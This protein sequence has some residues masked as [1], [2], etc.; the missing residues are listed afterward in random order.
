MVAVMLL[1]AVAHAA[2][3]DALLERAR[4]ELQRLDEKAALKT[5]EQ[6]RAQAKTSPDDLARVHL[7]TGLAY[8]GL[9][10]KPNAVKS[11]QT[12]LVL[13]PDLELPTWVS[14]VVRTWWA[15]AGGQVPP[16]PDAPLV[17]RRAPPSV[18]D[19]A[20]TAPPPEI[21]EPQQWKATRWVAIGL[22]AAAVG[23]AATGFLQGARAKAMASTA[24]NEL[25]L[26]RGLALRRQAES[27][28][29][30]A[31]ILFAVSGA[32]AAAG[33]VTWVW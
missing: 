28:A 27:S 22:S 8:A 29:T 21:T 26:D 15:E 16:E 33:A 14:P 30:T 1:A 32:L 17:E 18:K 24:E 19:P 23:T 7:Y 13:L 25:T 6:A 11:F 10:D 9:A 3:K 31:N 5:L 4:E 12:A 20:F 2:A